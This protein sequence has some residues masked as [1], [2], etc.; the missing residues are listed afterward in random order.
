MVAKGLDVVASPELADRSSFILFFESI[1]GVS[2]DVLEKVSLSLSLALKR[3]YSVVGWL[4]CLFCI[5]FLSVRKSWKSS[6]LL[7]A[8][9]PFLLAML[10]SGRRFVKFMEAM[11]AGGIDPSSYYVLERSL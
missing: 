8:W 2:L 3:L 10:V 6:S 11:G 7:R 4:L 5:C 1:H 9:F